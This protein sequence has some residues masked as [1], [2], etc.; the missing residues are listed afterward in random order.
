MLGKKIGNSEL[1]HFEAKFLEDKT[2]EEW[3]V[4][5]EIKS[6]NYFKE[7]KGK[8]GGFT[9]IG[10]RQLV[11]NILQKEMETTGSDTQFRRF[12]GRHGFNKNLN[13]T[14]F[15][16]FMISFHTEGELSVIE[17]DGIGRIKL[18]VEFFKRMQN[19]FV[20]F[21]RDLKLEKWPSINHLAWALMVQYYY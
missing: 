10:L 19:K 2:L 13:S 5:D 4:S 11:R 6:I 3:K 12:F 7:A 20:T 9:Q 21:T 15:R 8:R 16:T 17:H 18:D 14:V 1:E